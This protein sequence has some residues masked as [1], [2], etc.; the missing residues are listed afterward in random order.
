MNG[1]RMY[2][3]R[4]AWILGVVAVLVVFGALCLMIWAIAR[5]LP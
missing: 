4:P 1:E 5:Y 2:N 3:E